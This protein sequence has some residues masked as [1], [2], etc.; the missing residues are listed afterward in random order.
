MVI[1]LALEK[2]PALRPAFLDA[3]CAGD[4]AL[5]ERTEALLATRETDAVNRHVTELV[6]PADAET[7]AAQN[8][9]VAATWAARG[10]ERAAAVTLRPTNT[11]GVRLRARIASCGP[12]RA[13]LVV[14]E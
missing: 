11:F 1:A 9:A 8:L 13:A 12:P 6:V 10:E 2:S 14:F 5:R 3:V 7:Q 4:P